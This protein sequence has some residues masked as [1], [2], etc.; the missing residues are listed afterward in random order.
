MSSRRVSMPT[1]ASTATDQNLRTSPRTS[2]EDPREIANLFNSYFISIFSSE[3]SEIEESC[4]PVD[5][6]IMNDLCLTV[7]DVQTILESLDVTKATGPDAIP[8][9]LLKETAHVI[10]PPLSK[11]FNKSLS[12]G[13]VPLEWKEANVVPVF[14]K[15]EDDYT[16]NYRPISLLPLVSKVLEWYVLNSF[17]DRLCES[18][19]ARQHGFLRGKS[20]TSNLLEVLHHIGAMLDKG[21]QVDTVYMDM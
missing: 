13:T 4:S 19:K 3:D 1:E 11:L 6:P 16:E 20:C 14:K 12:T 2:A 9:R 18:I 15:G 8:A 10:A 5:K 21:G 17:K 7:D